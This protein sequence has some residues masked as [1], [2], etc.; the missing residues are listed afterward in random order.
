MV[1]L[2]DRAEAEAADADNAG[3]EARE[4]THLDEVAIL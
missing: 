1:G 3:T 2:E 4:V